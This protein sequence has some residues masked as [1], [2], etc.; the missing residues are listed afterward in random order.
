[1]QIHTI[2]LRLSN[3][4]IAIDTRAIVFD[5]GCEGE[6]DK[7]LRACA[8]Q[9]VQPHNIGAIVLTHGHGDHAGAARELREATGAPV[10]VHSGDLAMVRS[11]KNET[12]VPTSFEARLIKLFANVSYT[13]FEPDHVVTDDL[14]LDRFGVRAT[15]RSLPGHTDGSTVTT[16]SNGDAIVGDLIRGGYMGGV[17]APRVPKWH[18]FAP[19]R[20]AVASALRSLLGHPGLGSLYVGHGGPV[21]ASDARGLLK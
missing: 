21:K 7:I 5:A 3:V 9:G 8:S 10:I 17:V 20:A 18:Y 11:G 19:D 16:L 4:H 15:M 1:V 12:L 2:R 6:G 13:G 14:D